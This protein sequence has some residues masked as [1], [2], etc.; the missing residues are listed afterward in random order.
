MDA[1]IANDETF[2]KLSIF[3]TQKTF[4]QFLSQ[5]AAWV[6][7]QIRG[8]SI[9]LE[10]HYAQ[11]VRLKMFPLAVIGRSCLDELLCLVGSR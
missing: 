1:T 3:H 6:N 9:P 10:C 2:A 11:F 7:W 5:G 4:A 8:T